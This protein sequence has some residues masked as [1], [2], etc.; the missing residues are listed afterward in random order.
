MKIPIVM[1]AFGTT[2][3]ACQSYVSLDEQIRA[4]FPGHEVHWAFSSRLVRD[5][6]RRRHGWKAKGPTEI[7]EEL[8]A[9]GVEWAVVQSLHLLAGHEFY[10][11]VEEVQACRIRTAMGLPLLWA[12]EDYRAFLESLAVKLD[13]AGKREALVLVGHGTDHASWATYPALQYLLSRQFGQQVYVGALEGHPS[14]QE[15]VAEIV[16]SGFKRVRLQP[17]MLVAG[18]HLQKDLTGPENSWQAS[19]EKAGLS[20]TLHHSGLLDD[21]GVIKIFQ[22]H[23]GHALELIQGRDLSMAIK[24]LFL[25]PKYQTSGL[26]ANQGLCGSKL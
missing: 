14:R 8:R 26:V 10:R 11:L 3:S 22:D 12:S 25:A 19:F 1:A 23:I 6:S 20:V 24:P 21:P 4:T 17:L 15:V 18:H 7:L 13:P 16:K 2:T 9:R 5:F